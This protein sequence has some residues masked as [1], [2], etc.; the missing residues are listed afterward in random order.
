[1]RLQRIDGGLGQHEL[2]APQNVIDV[3]A[4]DRQHVDIGN[5]A[6]GE[7]EV[8]LDLGAVDDQGVVETELLEA[9]LQLAGLGF[10]QRERIDD[11]DRAVLGLGRERVAQRE[12]AHLL[13]H[14]YLVA[15]RGRT[16]RTAAAAEQVH[17]R[18]A[19]TGLTGALLLVH[20]LARA[21][22]FRT[23]LHVM[24]AALALGE[25]PDHVAL[26]EIV[27]RLEAEDLVRQRDFAAVL[28]FEGGD[29]EFHHAPS[30]AGAAASAGAAAPAPRNL[31]GFG[32]SFGSAFFTASR[33]VIQPP[34][35][36]GTAPSTMIRP[37]SISSCTTR[38]LS[39]VM[40]STPIWPGIF[41]FLK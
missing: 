36:P 24:G 26:N 30:P 18:R 10:L 21:P 15:A 9:L 17:A 25:L 7:T 37:R 20:L 3:D 28:A 1:A 11:D 14:A 4:L 35:A 2:P 29:F 12:R 22:D 23:V 27:A 5:A 34:L 16:E 31:P 33:T 32:A 40:R 8:V 41:L 6:R 39:V 13:R 38:R 19:V